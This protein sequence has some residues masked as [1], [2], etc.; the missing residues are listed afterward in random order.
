MAVIRF[1][2][3]LP[4][5]WEPHARGGR[6]EWKHTTTPAK[7]ARI[8]SLAKFMYALIHE[9]RKRTNCRGSRT[10]DSAFSVPVGIAQDAGGRIVP[11]HPF[12]TSPASPSTNAGCDIP[13]SAQNA[14][15]AVADLLEA[16]ESAAIFVMD[17]ITRM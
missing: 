15:K 9:E 16:Q 1:I 13:V 7:N 5:L 10:G 12:K 2:G 14:G 17:R 8:H 11:Q 3:I 6:H 4:S